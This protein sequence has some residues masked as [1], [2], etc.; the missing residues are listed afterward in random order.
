MGDNGTH[1]HTKGFDK[2]IFAKPKVR[3]R[4]GLIFDRT[5]YRFFLCITNDFA[6][7]NFNHAIR[8]GGNFSVVGYHN[9]SV[10]FCV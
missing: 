6:I 8:T 4:F 10:A 5:F 3:F 2:L 9:N 1:R 7:F